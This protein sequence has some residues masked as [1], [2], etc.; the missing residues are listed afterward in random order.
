MPAMKVN[1]LAKDDLF[2]QIEYR[3]DRCTL[4]GKCVASIAP[5]R[6]LKQ[7]WKKKESGK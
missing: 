1:E 2:W 6:Q 4:C 7:K 3:H 5:L